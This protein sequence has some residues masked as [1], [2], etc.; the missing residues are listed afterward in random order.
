MKV[1]VFSFSKYVKL[2]T[3]DF[4]TNNNVDLKGLLLVERM[5]DAVFNWIPLGTAVNSI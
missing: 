4:T 1:R 5:W 2:I 3:V